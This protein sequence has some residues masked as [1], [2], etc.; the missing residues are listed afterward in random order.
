MS[1]IQKPSYSDARYSNLT[2]PERDR[3]YKRDL[4]LYEQQEQLR[5]QNELQQRQLQQQ[6]QQMRVQQQ[7]AKEQ[8]RLMQ[9]QLNQMNNYTSQ[10]LNN[11][12]E[13][14]EEDE[15]TEDIEQQIKQEENTK[16]LQRYDLAYLL[17]ISPK[18]VEL[19]IDEYIAG[20]LG[21]PKDIEEAGRQYIITEHKIWKLNEQNPQQKLYELDNDTTLTQLKAHKDIISRGILN[22]IL[23]KRRINELEIQIQEE[24]QK[25]NNLRKK[26]N[27]ELKEFKQQRKE[28]IQQSEEYLKTYRAWTDKT[29][30][31]RLKEFNNFRSTHYNESVELHLKQILKDYKT[32]QIKNYGN[33]PDYTKYINKCLKS[34]KD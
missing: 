14:D 27:K 24:E 26:Y 28:L 19:F 29:K 3:Q 21:M 1:Y 6:K 22:K 30:E 17:G 33:I 12:N 8:N 15:D 16:K 32:I 11:Y 13:Y 9:E 34:I 23:N 7:L 31:D 5:K 25:Q 2:Y 4:M 20:S 18:S 10:P